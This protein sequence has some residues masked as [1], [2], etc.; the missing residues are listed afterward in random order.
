MNKLCLQLRIAFF[1]FMAACFFT[2]NAKAGNVMTETT[3]GC[4]YTISTT[5]WAFASGGGTGYID[6]YTQSECTWTAVASFPSGDNG[7]W[8]TITSGS[9]GTGNGTVTF[10]V[11]PNPDETPR[12]AWITIE[13]N[14]CTITQ[15][16]NMGP[17]PCPLAARVLQGDL[18]SLELLRSYRD[19]YLSKTRQGEILTILYYITSSQSV[20]VLDNNPGLIFEAR[21]LFYDNKDAISDVLAGYEGII[22]NTDEIISFLN[23]YAEESPPLLKA[24]LNIIKEDMLEQKREGKL[25]LGFRLQ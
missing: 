11:A 21:R 16:G 10:S 2:S 19:E 20:E 4:S 6:V 25:F 5:A 1:I 18:S 8:L 22:F 3:S 13:G 17:I 9:S 23:N 7:D 15:G 24:I 12:E 14:V